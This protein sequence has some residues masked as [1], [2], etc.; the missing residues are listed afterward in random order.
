M[1]CELFLGCLCKHCSTALC[2]YVERTRSPVPEQV[3]SW[4]QL[5][6]M[7]TTHLSHEC[8]GTSVVNTLTQLIY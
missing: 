5:M 3:N 8:V 1:Y 7:I 4:E 6:L 2:G